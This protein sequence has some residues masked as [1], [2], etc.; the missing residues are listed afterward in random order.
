MNIKLRDVVFIFLAI[1]CV[2]IPIWGFPTH[3]DTGFYAFLSLIVSKGILPHRDFIIASHTYFAYLGGL[4]YKIFPQTYL[5]LRVADLFVALATSLSFYFF[6]TRLVSQRAAL[7]ATLLGSIALNSPIFHNGGWS[8]PI[9]L[10]L[11]FVFSAYYLLFGAKPN[12]FWV[13]FLLAASSLIRE[14]FV[15]ILPLVFLFIAVNSRSVKSMLHF[16]CGTTVAYLFFLAHMLAIG[17][18]QNLIEGYQNRFA[19]FP[20]VNWSQ[21]A[22]SFMR[23]WLQSTAAYA[24]TLPFVGLYLCDR[25]SLRL[26][27]QKPQTLDRARENHVL[28]VLLVQLLLLLWINNVRVYHFIH[29]IPLLSVM[30]AFAFDKQ[31]SNQKVLLSC[32]VLSFLLLGFTYWPNFKFYFDR[33]KYFWPVMVEG[34]HDEEIIGSDLFLFTQDFLNKKLQ[35]HEG[36]I[37]SSGMHYPVLLLPGDD[38]FSSNLYPDVSWLQENHDRLTEK[39]MAEI[40]ARPP[41]YFLRSNHYEAKNK[42]F[43]KFIADN[44]VMYEKIGPIKHQYCSYPLWYIDVYQHK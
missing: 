27:S 33:S 22:Q 9:Y 39:F 36:P 34:K 31:R 38:I 21:K 28:F 29:C 26:S 11:A 4:I 5:T 6:L 3:T 12:Y 19:D 40:N 7:I 41:K 2:R 13:G 43:E 25:F 8:H 24:F 18:L 37:L 20:L 16:A 17:G 1:A 35:Q 32:T 14:P 42:E 44:Y 23:Y 15:V 10:A 30:M